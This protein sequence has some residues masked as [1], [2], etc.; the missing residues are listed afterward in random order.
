MATSSATEPWQDGKWMQQL[1]NVDSVGYDQY[2]A[3]RGEIFINGEAKEEA[4]ELN[5]PGMRQRRWGPHKINHLRRTGCIIGVC[6]DG[7]VFN[8]GGMSS[9]AGLTQ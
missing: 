6:R 8:I 1:E 5:L 7:M 4:F 2:G 9:N 3:M